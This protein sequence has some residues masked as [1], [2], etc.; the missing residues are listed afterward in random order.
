MRW[1]R[2]ALYSGSFEE[3]VELQRLLSEIEILRN[4]E[5]IRDWQM[6]VQ[7]GAIDRNL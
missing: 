7:L 5:K 4:P 2:Q 3:E 1:I 6:S